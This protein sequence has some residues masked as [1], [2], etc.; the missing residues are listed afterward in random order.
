MLT[1]PRSTKRVPWLRY[2][3]RK[4]LPQQRFTVRKL[5]RPFDPLCA[6]AAKDGGVQIA[7]LQLVALGYLKLL[8][9]LLDPACSD[10]LPPSVFCDLR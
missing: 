6:D 3:L 10:V 9:R 4:V 8:A 5:L 7:V 1:L 2:E